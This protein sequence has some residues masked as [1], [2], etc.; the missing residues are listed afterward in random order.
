MKM[1]GQAGS[2]ETDE[3]RSGG[4]RDLTS[5]SC[6]LCQKQN[7]VEYTN[8]WKFNVAFLEK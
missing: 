8:F 2:R 4:K 6:Y 1:A 3:K 5:F 7:F